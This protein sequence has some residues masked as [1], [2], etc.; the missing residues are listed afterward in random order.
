MK[1]I[2]FFF[3]LQDYT[4]DGNTSKQNSQ[5]MKLFCKIWIATE[6]VII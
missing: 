6:I 2:D 5:C 1:L 3:Q 4:A